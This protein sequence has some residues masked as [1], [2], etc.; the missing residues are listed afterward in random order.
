MAGAGIMEEL[1]LRSRSERAQL[2]DTVVPEKAAAVTEPLLISALL[3]PSA[4]LSPDL[5][6]GE[7]GMRR[8]EC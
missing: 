2:L 4:N 3:V 1:F 8:E 7:V 5:E 6:Q